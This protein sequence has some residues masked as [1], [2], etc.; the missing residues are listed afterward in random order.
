MR[1]RAQPS[2]TFGA[3]A[4]LRNIEIRVRPISLHS[5]RGTYPYDADT[6]VQ[7]QALNQDGEQGG[8]NGFSMM[9]R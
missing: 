2:F 9:H 5:I 8:F 4:E 6:N 3:G 1:K 7:V